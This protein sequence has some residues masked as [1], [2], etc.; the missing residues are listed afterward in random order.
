MLRECQFS[1]AFLRAAVLIDTEKNFL[2]KKGIRGSQQFL[3]EY[4]K[5]RS[6]SLVPQSTGTESA[7][8]VERGKSLESK[9]PPNPASTSTSVS[10]TS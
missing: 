3:E 2:R 5:Q 6:Q 1:K 8:S 7:S 9:N 4:K 10:Y